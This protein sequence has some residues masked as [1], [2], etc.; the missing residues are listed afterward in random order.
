M[1]N[2]GALV[3]G[4]FF[5]GIV[6]VSPREA[7]AT[8]PANLPPLPWGGRPGSTNGKAVEERSGARL[9]AVAPMASRAPSRDRLCTERKNYIAARPDSELP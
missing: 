8:Q 9:R 6:A 1:Q 4:P 7:Q 3:Y 5:Q 2:I